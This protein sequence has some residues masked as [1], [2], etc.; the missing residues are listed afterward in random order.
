MA[1]TPAHDL[2]VPAADRWFEDYTPGAVCE[3]GPVTFSAAD[4]VEFARRYDPQTIHTDAAGAAAGPLGGLIASG[5][6][7]VGLVMRELV[8]HYLSPVAALVSP[9]VDELRWHA[10]V[11]PGD[12]LRVRVTIVEARRSQSKPDR[13]L[14]RS[15]V[16]AFNQRDEIVQSFVAMN[17]LRCRVGAPRRADR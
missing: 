16:E 7:T 6:H 4:I 15:R 17:L 3:Y 9:G 10:P 14:V 11:R 8:E 5:W 2:P 13:G 1:A 12:T